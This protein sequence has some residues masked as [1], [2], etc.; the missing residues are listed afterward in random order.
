MVRAQTGSPGPGNMSDL[1]QTRSMLMAKIR[2]RNTAPERLLRAELRI[3][4]LNTR[5]NPATRHGRPDLGLPGRVCVFVDGCFWHGCP[6]HYVRP[7]TRG[8]FWAAKLRANVLRD[9]RQT[10]ALEADGWRVVRLWEHEVES[11]P[12]RSADKVEAVLKRG[13]RTRQTGW[14]VLLAAPKDVAGDQEPRLLVPLKGNLRPRLTLARRTT[15]KW[16]RTR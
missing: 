1:K 14:R 7:R 13:R 9:I 8:E 5:A 16:R 12:V 11:D 10:A 4:G 2:G 15:A 6:E 3:R